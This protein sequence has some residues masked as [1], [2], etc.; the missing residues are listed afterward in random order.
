MSSGAVPGSDEFPSM[1]KNGAQGK[2][3]QVRK[4]ELSAPSLDGWMGWRK[5]HLPCSLE[6]AEKATG[7]PSH[8]QCP[9]YRLTEGPAWSM[10]RRDW[11]AVSAEHISPSGVAC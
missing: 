8:S 2:D 9:L 11:W 7:G 5:W 10:L 4:S 6:D 3:L 1:V